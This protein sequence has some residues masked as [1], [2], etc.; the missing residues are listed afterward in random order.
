MTTQEKRKRVKLFIGLS[1]GLFLIANAILSTIG[2][3]AGLRGVQLF[4]LLPSETAPAVRLVI[5]VIGLGLSW[6]IGR[7]LYK[8]LIN[9]EIPLSDSTNTA[10]IML[11]YLL[12]VFAALS[13]IGVLNGFILPILFVILLFFSVVTLWRL[14]GV[15]VAF[16]SVA[17]AFTAAFLTFYL[18]N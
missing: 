11:F 8:F 1:F 14:I 12:L 13:F 7:M 2:V 16:G 5:F 18:I 4:T 3:V 10:Y 15:A 9:G 17:A 6:L